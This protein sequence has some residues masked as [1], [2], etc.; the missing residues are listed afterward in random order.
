VATDARL[1]AMLQGQDAGAIVGLL[2]ANPRL[3]DELRQAPRFTDQASG[4]EAAS[5]CVDALSAQP[6]VCPGG[7]KGYA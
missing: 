1:E 2:Q 7:V 3:A 6:S 5:Y 4:R